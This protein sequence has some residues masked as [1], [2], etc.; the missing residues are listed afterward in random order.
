MGTDRLA[1][2]CHAVRRYLERTP[3]LVPV[4]RVVLEEIGDGASDLEVVQY[5][6]RDQSGREAVE[7]IRQRLGGGV[8]LLA[9][10]ALGNGR[11]PAAEG[12]VQVRSGNVVT[13]RCKR[14]P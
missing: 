11:Y 4:L 10:R 9:W 7:S 13:Y 1:V 6:E 2:S 12:Y 8:A 14:K 5:I 3:E